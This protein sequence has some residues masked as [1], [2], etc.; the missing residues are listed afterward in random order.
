VISAFLE[1]ILSALIAPIL[2]VI[3]SGA[4]FQILLG[5]D[6]GW[7]PQ[8]RDDGSIPMR[9]IVRR[10]RWHAFLGLVA[11]LSAFMI[12][13]SLFL[14]MSPT[15][16]GLLLAIPLSWLSGRLA[17]GLAL[18]RLGLL[19]IPEETATPPIVSRANALQAENARLGF[20]DEDGLL[21]L[22]KDPELREAH[23]EMLPPPP[24][25]RRGDIEPERVMAQAKVMDAESIHDALSWLKPKER[26]VVLHD[27]ALLDQ[28][29][30]LKPVAEAAE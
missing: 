4:V 29:T 25:R 19:L 14:W 1:I 12:A 20:D 2:M 22:Y 28:L 26:M 23:E 15:I 24:P 9:D 11:G 3:Q 21:A 10:H 6:T 16:I 7:Q 5:R 13:T 17:A 18:K 30:R 8:R 27:R